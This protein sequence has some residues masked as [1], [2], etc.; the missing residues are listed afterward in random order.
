MFL[1]G[2]STFQQPHRRTT[3][4]S[5]HSN[6]LGKTT[7]ETAVMERFRRHEAP[8]K[9]SLITIYLAGISAGRIADITVAQCDSEDF[10]GN[11]KQDQPE[12]LQVH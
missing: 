6:K 11:R 4:M 10:L 7:F 5:N 8:I 2:I 9:E 3:R 1:V 12:G